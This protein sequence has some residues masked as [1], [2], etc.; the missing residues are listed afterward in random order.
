MVLVV[1]CT[2]TPM[3]T[4]QTTVLALLEWVLGV[5]RVMALPLA[6]APPLPLA[7]PTVP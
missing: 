6:P 3:A 1:Q 4:L 2:A 7:I 5:W